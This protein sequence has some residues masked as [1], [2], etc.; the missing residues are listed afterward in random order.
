LEY[1]IQTIITKSPN[2][3]IIFVGTHL[4]Q[5]EGDE[6]EMIDIEELKSKYPQIKNSIKIS[7]TNGKNCDELKE[8]IY[9]Y[10]FQFDNVQYE[11]P[12]NYLDFLKM[13]EE[14][15]VNMI[16]QSFVK[17]KIN[18]NVTEKLLNIFHEWGNIL[19]LKS[20]NGNGQFIF[21]KPQL[22]SQIYSKI[23]SIK[24]SDS[25]LCENGMIQGIINL[26]KIPYFIKNWRNVL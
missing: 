6:E 18:I 15:E 21:L 24:E 1:W 13:I 12:R 26:K 5:M 2:A 7:S 11:M 19:V 17:N 22:L 16:D 25:D 14:M 8:M 23:I 20:K 4:D 3:F 9:K 10:T